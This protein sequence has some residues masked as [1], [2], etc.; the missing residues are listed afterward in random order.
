MNISPKGGSGDGANMVGGAFLREVAKIS[1]YQGNNNRLKRAIALPIV[2]ARIKTVMDPGGGEE[3]IGYGG[4]I[5]EGQ[6][7]V[8][9]LYE[10]KIRSGQVT[11][12][13]DTVFLL[14]IA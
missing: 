11:F 5:R 9:P 14:L 6:Q 1:E 10:L 2:A 8:L 12:C 4:R 3:F 13:L 7:R